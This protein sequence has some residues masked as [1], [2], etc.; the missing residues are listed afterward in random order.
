MAFKQNV[1]KIFHAFTTP[2][3]ALITCTVGLIAWFFITVILNIY[4]HTSHLIPLVICTVA[5]IT[6]F[7]TYIT[8]VVPAHKLHTH[9]KAIELEIDVIK[10]TNA[11]LPDL[12]DNL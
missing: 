12:F 4:I 6:T 9:M 11:L 10:K 8:I 5:V 7:I 3:V 1:D 2:E